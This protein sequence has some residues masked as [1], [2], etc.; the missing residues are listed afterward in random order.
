MDT[1][2]RRRNPV[3]TGQLQ[4]PPYQR[5]IRGGKE[6]L[7]QAGKTL[8]GRSRRACIHCAKIKMRCDDD[9]SCPAPPKVQDQASRKASP[10]VIS[11]N[12]ESLN[13][14]PVK[15]SQPATKK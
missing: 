5:C 6:C 4:D 1:E 15:R 10:L 13:L 7:E 9:K 8:P 12:N 3:L 11:S 14:P 2:A